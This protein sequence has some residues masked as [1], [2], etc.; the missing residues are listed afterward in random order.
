MI[1][2]TKLLASLNLVRTPLF[3][4]LLTSLNTLLPT[5]NYYSYVIIFTHIQRLHKAC[6]RIIYLFKG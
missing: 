4:Y 1:H 2:N 5:V 3:F 6:G